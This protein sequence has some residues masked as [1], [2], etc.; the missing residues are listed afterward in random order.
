M[1]IILVDIDGTLALRGDRAPH[2]HESSMEDGVNWPVVKVVD[3]F[4]AA[5]FGEVLLISGREEQYR[6]VTEYWLAAHHL[7][8]YRIDLL[9]RQTKDNRPD[10]IVKREIYEQIVKPRYE[11][12]AVV[13]D[14]NKVV[15]MWRN[16]GLLCLQ[17]A[18]GDF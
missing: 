17:V 1:K 9:M 14:R 18:D 4:H 11:V 7:M 15:R 12:V 5:H 10:E 2:D 16:L 3:A 8:P 6:D 13:D